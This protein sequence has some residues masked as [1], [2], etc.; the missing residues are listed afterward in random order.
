MK[1]CAI[2]ENDEVV[3]GGAEDVDGNDGVMNNEHDVG[4]VEQSIRDYLAE[5]VVVV[6]VCSG[7]FFE[8]FSSA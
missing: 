5:E 7:L 8:V 2:D 3:G 4:D 6:A 1:L